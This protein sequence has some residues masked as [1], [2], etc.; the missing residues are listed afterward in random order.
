[1][2]KR[3]LVHPYSKMLLRIE[4]GQASNTGNT[5]M[6][7]RSIMLSEARPYILYD[8]IYVNLYSGRGK[9][10]GTKRDQWLQRHE[11]I[12]RGG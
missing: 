6:N 2:G 3:S 4:E 5:W 9:T 12:F 8:P 1:M 7:V 10:I 11:G